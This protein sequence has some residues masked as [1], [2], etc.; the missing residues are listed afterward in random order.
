[1]TYNA[2]VT[3]YNELDEITHTIECPDV[4]M[5]ALKNVNKELFTFDGK[6]IKLER[7]VYN[8]GLL[9]IFDEILTNATDNLQRKGSC[10]KNIVVSINKDDSISVYN[11][12]K[13]IPIEKNEKNIWI[14]ELIFTRF[15][16]GSNFKKKNKTTGGKNGIGSKLTSVFSKRFEIDIINGGKRYYQKVENNCR[17]INEP[18]IEC[19]I[20]YSEY[21]NSI[22]ITFLPDYDLL[23]CALTEDNKKVLY[24]RVHD[25][26]YL[27]INICLNNKE[28]PRL[29]WNEYVN[30][31]KISPKLYTYTN[32]RWR[33]AF[34]I[35]NDKHRNISYVNNISTYDG[36]EHV[37]YIID[38]IYNQVKNKCDISKNI[39]RSKIVVIVSAIIDDPSFT[40]QAKEKLSTLPEQFGS[41]C[42]IPIN[43]INEFIKYT[44]IIELLKHT[45]KPIKTKIKKGRI[46]NV[47]NLDEANRAGV[48]EGWKCTL[49]LCE[50]LSAKTMC[51]KGI[52]ILGH[53]YYG[54]Y[55]LR[56]KLL[57]AR[58]ASDNKYNNNKELNDI[59]EIIGL[60]D[61][62]TYTSV[63]GLRYGK[64][65]C[66]KDADADGASI[67]GLIMNFFES[68]FPSLLNIEGF[69]SEFI[70]PMIKVIYNPNDKSKRNV[71]PFYN[72]VEYRK[73]ISDVANE[74]NHP[75]KKKFSVEFIKGLAT[76]EDVDIKEY[77]THYTDNKIEIM[78]ND[79]YNAWFD[80]A[81]NSKRANDRKSWLTTITPDTCLPR[82]KGKPINVT[83]FI[84]SDLVLFSYDS[85]VRSI[86]SCIDGLKPSQRKILY[87]LFKMGN[88][89]FDKMKVFQLGGLVAKKANYHHGDQ[90]MNAT[91]IGMA[92]DF[93]GCG[94]NIPLLKPSGQFGS[95]TEYGDD[96][97]APRYISCSLNKITRMIFP[98]I[99]DTL[100]PEKEEDNQ[101]VEP[102]YY[103]PIIPMILV[104]GAKGIGTGWSTDIPS[105]DPY[106]IIEY[107]QN[108]IL[109]NELNK[110][111]SYY[112]KY[113]GDIT[114]DND[115]WNYH[116][117]VKKINDRVFNVTELPIRYSTRRFINRMNFLIKTS[118]NNK[119]NSSETTSSKNV[120]KQ[121]KTHNDSDDAKTN[122][123]NWTP[124]YTIQSFENRSTVDNIDFIIT[125][126]EPQTIENVIATLGLVKSIKN[127]NM[128]A[129]D[130][131][132]MIR[133]FENI[134]DIINEWFKIRYNI[135][136]KR[137]DKIIKELEL[138]HKLLTNKCR[139]IEENI[140]KIIDVKNKPKAEIINTLENR[141]Y[142]KLSYNNT[143]SS[144]DYLLNM[145]IYTLTKEKY[146]SL[147]NKMK[148]I[149]DKVNYYKSLTVE[150][151]W[152]NEL[153]DLRIEL[154]KLYNEML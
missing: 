133:K 95:R 24:K 137:I 47:D 75:D 17:T 6:D 102:Y 46:T 98:Q 70:S 140:N 130:S 122:S 15:R 93:T 91:I 28:L 44:N 68:K 62:V 7:V 61:G 71:I 59:K 135:Y 40:S 23:G 2:Q 45:K 26:I 48:A 19:S 13:T 134:N 116:G 136:D 121:N 89:C 84:K 64:V 80:M 117:I 76:N 41:T 39:L 9:K 35:T 3:D 53:D 92:Q 149:N 14:P 118:E 37:K 97:G 107:V 90:S 77:F 79:N 129:F 128:V 142:D 112:F 66:V 31:F 146:E 34:G 73:F 123:V 139:F 49:F 18:V 103:A 131:N 74:T 56:G 1:M 57:N 52:G 96:A 99:D 16:S 113:N 147:R 94:N 85:C 110:V 32:D 4:Y 22:T 11:D 42:I 83:D 27:P 151:L 105:F 33:V 63:K 20:D 88:K 58:N 141:K 82:N 29:T 65:V 144:Y 50:G 148:E 67:M 86:P 69:F 43:I 127:S 30:T 115:G 145:K 114:E 104:N 108:K 36:G 54:C 51:D 119:N 38:Q 153:N 55:P 150:E 109:M 100:T 21:D 138:E 132:N 154:D 143:E 12:G 5:G 101:I 25:M 78:F 10:I 87:T 124:I 125:F 8:T 60:Q 81:F 106:E 120:N 152:I 111:H 126:T 72:E